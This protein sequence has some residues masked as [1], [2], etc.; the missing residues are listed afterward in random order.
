[1][2]NVVLE[3]KIK[4]K[5]WDK[6]RDTEIFTAFDIT[7]AVRDENPNMDVLHYEVRTVVH[8]MFEND[9]FFDGE[10]Y[11]RTLVKLKCGPQAL[12]FHTSDKNA[13]DHPEA[14]LP[15]SSALPC[16]PAANDDGVVQPVIDGVNDIDDDDNVASP[17]VKGYRS[18][19]RG[20]FCI[21]KDAL[22]DIG[23]TSGYAFVSMQ[24][25]KLIVASPTSGIRAT[26]K[27][28]LVDEH[29]NLRIAPSNLARANL[30]SGPR[31]WHTVEK[32]NLYLIVK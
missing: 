28:L 18:D 7:K 9:E 19:S 23:V 16:G 14:A 3:Q 20:R 1:M 27:R 4:D 29:G 13:T 25:G 6:V 24:S 2:C 32:H 26:W 11:V 21:R 31:A 12:V 10:D 17:S 15:I 8:D 22:T 30:T 5:V